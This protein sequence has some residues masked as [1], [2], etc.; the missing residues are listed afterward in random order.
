MRPLRSLS[1][2]R[3]LKRA[4]RQAE[5]EGGVV[6]ATLRHDGK[7]VYF[8]AR[9]DATDAEMRARAFEA[10][11][12]RPFTQLERQLMATAVDRRHPA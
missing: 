6:C 4:R 9:P 12:G 7:P 5:R 2:K 11:E 1:N 10:R 8:T 3:R